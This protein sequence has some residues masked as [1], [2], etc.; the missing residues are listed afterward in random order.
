MNPKLITGMLIVT[1]ALIF[2]SIAVISEQRKKVLSPFIMATLT[3][4]L[5]LDAIATGFMIAGSRNLPFTA[6]GFLGY[7]AFTVMLVDTVLTWRFWR[8]DKKLQP[9]SRGLHLYTRIAYSWWVIA[10]LAGGLIA[11]IGLR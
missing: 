4:G 5:T 6:H 3:I 11:S 7:S 10:Y 1:T 2:Y 8:S 9:V